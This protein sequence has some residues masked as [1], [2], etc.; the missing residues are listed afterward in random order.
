[1]KSY[2]GV[3]L[4]VAEPMTRGEY[5]EYRGWNIPADEN[6]ADEG[7]LVKYPDGYVS[8]SPKAVFDGAYRV[9]E[10]QNNSIS[11]QDVEEFIADVEAI[12]LGEKTTVVKATLA[13]G[14]I[15]VES[16]SCVDAANFSMDIGREICMEK[17]RDKV[18]FLLGFLLQCAVAGLNKDKEV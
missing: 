15:L 5:I 10:G 3:K 12:Q 6:P 17:I 4:I 18:W 11:P 9:I 7:Y 14:F 13:N 1:M 8:W 16:S 2:I